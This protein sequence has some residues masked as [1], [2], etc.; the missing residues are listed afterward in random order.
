MA[1]FARSFEYQALHGTNSIRAIKLFPALDRDRPIII[2]LSEFPLNSPIEYEAL[3]YTWDDQKPTRDITCNEK[4]LCVT[5]NVF[6]ALR[7]LGGWKARRRVLWIDAICL[8][9][10]QYQRRCHKNLR[11]RPLFFGG[12]VLQVGS[13]FIRL[14]TALPILYL[15][16]CILTFKCTNLTFRRYYPESKVKLFQAGA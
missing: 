14:H 5:E 2:D 9:V 7:Q 8:Y 6:Q 12:F 1:R 11:F 15:D 3:S 13:T 16:R 10:D 4:S